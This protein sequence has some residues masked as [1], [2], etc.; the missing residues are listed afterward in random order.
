MLEGGSTRCGKK[1]P[2]CH[3]EWSWASGPPTK[4]K[5]KT[6]PPR[7][8]GSMSGR[9]WIRAFAGMTWLSTEFPWAF[10]PAEEMKIPLVTPAQ[11]GVHVPAK[12]DSRFRGN[13]VVGVILRTAKGGT[14]P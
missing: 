12:V 10:G 13:D 1:P 11:A 9:N 14:S 8:R 4:M 6:S 2:S 5:V 3:S 7:K